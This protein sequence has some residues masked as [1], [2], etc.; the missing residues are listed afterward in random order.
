MKPE[1]LSHILNFETCLYKGRASVAPLN[2]G[3]FSNV[4]DSAWLKH[5]QITKVLIG[6][7]H[8]TMA[9]VT[10]WMPRGCVTEEKLHSTVT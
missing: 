7:V 3:S 8:R 9:D 4:K 2:T 6:P 5:R 10:R 1:K